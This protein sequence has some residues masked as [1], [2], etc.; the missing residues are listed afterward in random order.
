[1]DKYFNNKE[2]IEELP[3]KVPIETIETRAVLKKLTTTRAALAE[4][5]GVAAT[6]PN[7]QILV[8]T[9]SLQEA[10]DSSAIENIVTTHDELYRSDY[11][12]KKYST[13]AAKEVHLYAEGLKIG[14]DSIRQNE[15]ITI[16]LILKIQEI[17]EGNKAG[18]RKLPGTVLKNE[19]TGDVIY[20]PPQDY[21]TIIRLLSN[22]E[23]FINDS[24]EYPVDP[25]IKM[26]L[27]HH[28]FESI[29]PFYDANGRTGRIINILY[30]IKENLIDL[31][32]LYISR[33]IITTRGTYYKLLQETRRSQQW[34]D[35]IMYILQAVEETA[36]ES[37][38]VIKEIKKLMQSYKDIIRETDSK[39]YSQD[40]INNLFRHP[41]TKIALLEKDLSVSRITATKYLERL[42]KMGLLRK[43]KIGRSNYYL[44]D[45]LL[46]LLS[47]KF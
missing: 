14:F 17:I 36:I 37:V 10:K 27:I 1:M 40:L 3:P 6:I 46:K 42:C 5:K 29:H 22:L 39:M 8:D 15:P 28:Q 30:L 7:E 41:Y 12:E 24:K 20:T 2:E 21:D 43:L 47:G 23:K 34:E 26:A 25:L 4:L 31:P 18:L 16:K 38:V 13:P 33:Y 32:I 35:W 9:L 45:P 44:N 11:R 19:Q